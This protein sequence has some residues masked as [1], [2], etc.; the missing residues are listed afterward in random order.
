M[1]SVQTM[2]LLLTG[3][4]VGIVLGSVPTFAY[5]KSKGINV[6]NALNTADKAI[7][8]AQPVINVAKEILPDNPIVNV[9][10]LIDKYAVTGVKNAEQLYHA[11][12]LTTNEDR[13]KA[14]HDTVYAALKEF[15]IVPSDNQKK[16]IDDTIEA[17]VNDLGHK[18]KSDAEK[19]A[20]KQTLKTQLTQI[21]AERDNLKNTIATITATANTVQATQ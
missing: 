8:D 4:I 13:S 10:D 3:G 6:G 14:A 5:L 19:E 9:I 11:S 2:Q 18:D 20:E 17:A 12:L 7:E 16:L 15:D 1:I 21:T